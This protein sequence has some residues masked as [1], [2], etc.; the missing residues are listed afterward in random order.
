MED[1]DMC[2]HT[3]TMEKLWYN[4]VLGAMEAKDLMCL[5]F[6]TPQSPR[7]LFLVLSQVVHFLTNNEWGQ[8]I[9][10]LEVF[11]VLD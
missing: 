6:L 5:M 2:T 9:S 3:H 1:T 11:W 8:N 7:A 4:H 10:D